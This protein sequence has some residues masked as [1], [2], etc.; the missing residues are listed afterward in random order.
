MR[1]STVFIIFFS[2][3]VGLATAEEVREIELNDGSVIIGEIVSLDEEFYT[4]RSMGLGTVRIERFKIRTIRPKPATE[5][6]RGQMNAI[7]QR[8]MNDDEIRA[9]LVAIE[10]DPEFKEIFEDPEI[11]N[12]VLSEDITGLMSNP[13]FLKLLDNPK[14]RKI[15]K[16]LEE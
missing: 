3:F 16:K 13:K 8:M 9:I 11:M 1:F 4:I 6:G 5:S 15:M 7:K 14:I 2:L 12:G 10:S